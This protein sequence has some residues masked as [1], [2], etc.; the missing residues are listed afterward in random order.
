MIQIAE[1]LSRKFSRSQQVKRK[2]SYRGRA[3]IEPATGRLTSGRRLSQNI[4]KGNF[5]EAINVMFAAAV[6][7]F[8]RMINK[9]KKKAGCHLLF[10]LNLFCIWINRKY[11][12][13]SFIYKLEK[14]Y[15]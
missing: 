14:L 8:K 13:I 11:L 3:A 1:P 10:F 15:F 9:W 4:Y 12:I 2:K 7:N 5:G 6:L